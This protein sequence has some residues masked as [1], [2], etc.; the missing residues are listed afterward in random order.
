MNNGKAPGVDGLPIEWYKIFWGK[1]KFFFHDLIKEI[2]KEQILHLTAR[3]G[4]ISLIEKLEKDPMYLDHWRPITLLCVD[5]KILDKVIALRLQKVL[6]SIINEC[7]VGFMKNKML[8][9]NLLKLLTVIDYCETEN[10]PAVAISVDFRKAF[11]TGRWDAVD[12][13]LQR[14][15]FGKFFRSL[16]AITNNQIVATVLNNGKWDKWFTINKGCRQ[17]S[18]SSAL[19]FVLTAEILSIK[20]RFNSKIKGIKVYKETVTLGQYADD[21]WTILSPE[22]ENI[23]HFLHE[24][25]QF[26]IF[27]GLTMN[28]QKTVAIRLGPARIKNF[29]FITKRTL[30]WTRIQ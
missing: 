28:L 6:P 18:P 22:A 27:S 2:T 17:G 21:L 16:V 13:A 26:E 9:K 7:Q 24:M 30:S 5:F 14:F 11:D 4:I 19:L 23:N 15:N 20:I 25:E 1:I 8:G 12:E 3:R 29:Q 10:I